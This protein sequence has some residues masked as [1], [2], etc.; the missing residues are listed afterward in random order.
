MP[1]ASLRGIFF[2]RCHRWLWFPPAAASRPLDQL[3]NIL[4]AVPTIKSFSYLQG[5]PAHG[6]PV[7]QAAELLHAHLR[8][9]FN[10]EIP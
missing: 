5:A 1:R 4:D 8:A 6:L 9:L 7:E 3:N 2:G 10:R